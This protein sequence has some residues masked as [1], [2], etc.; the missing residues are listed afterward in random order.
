MADLELIVDSKDVISAQ[1]ETTKLERNLKKL[2][3][4]Y[5]KGAVT[6]GTYEKSLKKITQEYKKLGVSSQKAT[7]QVRKY[8]RDLQKEKTA[9][10]QSRRAKEEAKEAQRR[11]NEETRKAKEAAKEAARQ[12]RERAA[13]LKATSK[14][15][16]QHEAEMESLR[17]K[18]DQTYRI[19]KQYEAGLE[20]I[21]MAHMAGAL[22]A[23]QMEREIESLGLEFQKMQKGQKTWS[24]QFVQGSTAA[25]KS[26]NQLGVVTQ[27]AGYQIGDFLVQVQ[28]GTNAF[29]AFGQ[30]A[31]QLV[32]V[33]P[34]LSNSLGVSAGKLIAISSGLGIAIPLA[35]ALGAA[36]MRT[37]GNS[38]TFEDNLSDLTET[39]SEYKRQSDLA[40]SSTIDLGEEFGN[41]S[42][43]IRGISEALAEIGKIKAIEAINKSLEKL[44]ETTSVDMWDSLVGFA[45]NSAGELRKLQHEFDLSEQQAKVLQDSFKDFA[46]AEGVDGAVKSAEA[47][48][49]N[50]LKVFGTVEK[51]PEEFREAFINAGKLAQESAKMNANLE[52]SYNKQKKSLEDQL[53]LKRKE[54]QFGRDSIQVFN[55]ELRQKKESL[56]AQI[57]KSNA[58]QTERM[59]LSL[60]VE[61][62]IEAERATY[63]AKDA[64]EGAV[65]ATTRWANMMSNVGA[66]INGIMS[67][68]S[69]LGGGIIDTA[70]KAARIRT[71]REGGSVRDGVIAEKR[72]R[73]DAQLRKEAE[74]ANIFEKAILKARKGLFEFNIVQDEA[75]AKLEEKSKGTKYSSGGG[76]GSGDSG[77]KSFIDMFIGDEDTFQ[78]KREKL[79]EWFE[80]T[81]ERYNEFNA[82][83]LEILREHNINKLSI[84]EE[85]Q[86]RLAEIEQAQR[87]QRLN[88]VGSFM[89]S[90]ANVLQQGGSKMVKV[91][92]VFSA[93]QGLINSYT[94]YT[95][96][97]KDPAF[98]GRPWARFSAAASVLASGLK[99]VQAI[100]AVGSGGSGSAS[101]GGGAGAG[102]GGDIATPANTNAEPQKVY[103]EGLDADS[104][105]S[106][107]M[108]SEI[109]DKFYEENEERG[110]VFVVRGA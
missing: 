92:S 31:T 104:L 59:Y 4:R 84:E 89:G 71:L 38:K 65:D 22:S 60:V 78:A 47:L 20:E 82:A 53:A 77:V 85:Y 87:S 79:D 11:L 90:M 67:S 14:A 73:F 30:Q 93:A 13:D 9:T 46:S 68:L 43:R 1:S 15:M 106:G 83:E 49:N 55:E 81:M 29:V 108:L 10:E 91:A 3:D 21:R 74:G 66:E 105:I 95:E 70:A 16:D 24:N 33:L 64:T 76:S 62:L 94:A 99:M 72:S 6:N 28:S 32:G 48:Y 97:L 25:G 96:M 26:A 58:T 18:Y 45:A 50:L 39:I 103:I 23:E 100:K 88:D 2:F 54:L 86:Q 56:Q 107:R 63:S 80:S 5:S 17:L 40:K 110:A 27:Q 36:W 44:S 101:A 35:T 75:I 52:T 51:I 37:S 69:Q 42:E 102:G 98:V 19:Q 109:F 12:E 41:Q 8:V 7:G 57:D 61:Q 34:M